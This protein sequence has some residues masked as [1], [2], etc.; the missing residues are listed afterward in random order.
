MKRSPCHDHCDQSQKEPEVPQANMNSLVVGNSQ[1][2]RVA[3][4]DVFFG[5]RHSLKM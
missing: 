4:L 2:T 1:L 5:G 3:T